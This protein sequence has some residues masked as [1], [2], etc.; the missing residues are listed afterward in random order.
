MAGAATVTVE[1]EVTGIGDDISVS[2]TKTI[3]VPA[4]VTH[5]YTIV[6]TAQTTAIQLFSDT[7]KIALAKIYGV[8][9]KAEVGTI[10]ILPDTAGTTTFLS[11]DSVLTLNVGEAAFLPINPAGNLGLKIDAAAV[12]DAFSWVILGKV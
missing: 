5:G 2:N 4:E 9:I 10:Y 11:T 12:T 6:D 3:T 8:F 1:L 7:T